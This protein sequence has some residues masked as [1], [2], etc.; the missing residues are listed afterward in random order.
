M[1]I[2]LFPNYNGNAI[3]RQYTRN[4]HLTYMG[5][6]VTGTCLGFA[7]LFNSI[8]QENK[9]FIF[10]IIGLIL[11]NDTIAAY[12]DLLKIANPYNEICKRAKEIYSHRKRV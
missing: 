4:K 1:K 10:G 6:S 12:R 5:S 3:T 9:S 2:N 7:N 8:D 11:I